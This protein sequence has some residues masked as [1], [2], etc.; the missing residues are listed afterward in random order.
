MEHHPTGR[1][2]V[3]TS[4]QDCRS[5]NGWI[6]VERR[7]LQRN[8]QVVADRHT[9]HREVGGQRTHND[10][11]LYWNRGSR[12]IA[13]K[14]FDGQFTDIDHML[15]GQNVGKRPFPTNVRP[16]ANRPF[17]VALSSDSNS[18]RMGKSNDFLRNVICQNSREIRQRGRVP[19]DRADVADR[20][21]GG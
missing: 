1:I 16:T 21:A 11:G 7:D 12:R 18:R 15:S 19:Q 10:I 13:V 2:S 4:K 8:W 9:N 5:I 14:R 20:Q 6:A 17:I 3:G